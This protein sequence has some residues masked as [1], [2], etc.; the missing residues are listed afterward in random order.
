MC[1]RE[2]G[3]Y[4]GAAYFFTS[5]TRAFRRSRSSVVSPGRSPSSVSAWRT[6]RRS[7]SCVI[8]NSSAIERIA[9]TARGARLDDRAQSSL[10]ALAPLVDTCLVVVWLQRL[11]VWSLQESRGGSKWRERLDGGRRGRK[12]PRPAVGGTR[13][14]SVG[15]CSAR[16]GRRWLG[17]RTRCRSRCLS[18]AVRDASASLPVA[19]PVGSW[20]RASGCGGGCT[21]P[22]VTASSSLPP[23][24]RRSDPLR[25]GPTPD[26]VG[27]VHAAHLPVADLV[28]DPDPTAGPN[29]THRRFFDP[30]HVFDEPRDP[31][32]GSSR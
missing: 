19:I 30:H 20:T 4:I 24:P 13:P 14:R 10:R 6:Q 28:T 21:P 7:V 32:V 3:A 1:S 17:V 15:G 29:A 27:V 22:T 16:R 31:P 18:C 5:S 12:A 8:P 25:R 9:A 2:A 26:S 11:T 23:L